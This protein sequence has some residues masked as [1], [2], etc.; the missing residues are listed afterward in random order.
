VEGR[1]LD[2]NELIERARGG[3]VAAYEEL[4]RGYQDIAFRTA[5]LL[6]GGA[7]EAEDAAQEAFTKAWYALGR[8]RAGAPFR[9]WLLQIVANE[10]RNRRRG[11]GR[12]AALALRASEDRRPVDAAPSPE[13]AVLANEQRR[14]L[15]DAVS[16]LRDEDRQVIHCRYFLELSEAETAAALGW[17]RGTV[18]SRLS[19]ALHRLRDQLGTRDGTAP[20]SIPSGGASG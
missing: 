18:K 7:S 12:R 20:S 2:E 6:S 3:D 8:F 19:R 5:F 16:R 9:P 1:P 15:L 13:A 17:P 10:A 11:A 14:T 4:V